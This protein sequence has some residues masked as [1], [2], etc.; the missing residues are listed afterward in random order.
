MTSTAEHERH[1]EQV[2]GEMAR[3]VEALRNRL[4]P[5]QLVDETIRYMKGSDGSL[6]L[7]NL[8]N[9][10]RDNPLALTLIGAGLAWMMA[11]PRLR[12]GN[13]HAEGRHLADDTGRH[14][15]HGTA[16]PM[17]HTSV[18]SAS[19]A[20]EGAVHKSDTD[21]R[22]WAAGAGEAVSGAAG[23]VGASA[24]AARREAQKAMSAT[25]ESASNAA[26]QVRRSAGQLT[27][28]TRRTFSETLEREPL[29]I[30][31]L[32]LAIGAAIGALIPTTAAEDEYL[33][34]ARDKLKD[35]AGDA[36]KRGVEEAKDVA[37][38]S[39]AAAKQALRDEDRDRPV[40]ERVSDAAKTAAETA[41][42][43]AKRKAEGHTST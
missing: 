42:E 27:E 35:Q 22:S 14:I 43:E 30:G 17:T 39:Y 16:G 38:K 31:A 24:G 40:A 10:A 1:A 26:D 4:S 21:Q 34:P 29:I 13:G 36:M 7:S 23:R 33:G 37:D 3:T 32:G 25:G 41:R 11:G 15:S 28:R 2:R 5:G 12:G 9:Q 20:A 19:S 6:A 8:K 18:G